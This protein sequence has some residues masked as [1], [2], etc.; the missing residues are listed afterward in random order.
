MRAMSCQCAVSLNACA[1]TSPNGCTCFKAGV[2]GRTCVSKPMMTR[3]LLLFG[4]T[5]W[6]RGAS[7]AII[8][9]ASQAKRLAVLAAGRGGSR[10]MKGSEKCSPKE[11]GGVRGE[12]GDLASKFKAFFEAWEERYMGCFGVCPLKWLLI[13][14]PCCSVTTCSMTGLVRIESPG[15]DERELNEVLSFNASIYV[16]QPHMSQPISKTLGK[17]D[18]PVQLGWA[19]TVE[20]P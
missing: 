5:Y 13:K 12:S 3:W 20:L 7:A 2:S 14:G 9:S 17:F 1:P 8:S 11:F 10:H 16:P 15:Y 19:M 18:R 6:H 4:L